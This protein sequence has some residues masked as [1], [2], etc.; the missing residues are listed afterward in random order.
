[1]CKLASLGL[2]YFFCATY[3]FQALEALHVFT[4]LTKV[5]MGD[6]AFLGIKMAMAVGWG[7][8]AFLDNAICVLG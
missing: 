1:M 6:N 8:N 2:Q 7:K 3:A 4:V 5:T